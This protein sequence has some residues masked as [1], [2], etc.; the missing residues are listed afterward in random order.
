M[1]INIKVNIYAI[2]NQ[3]PAWYGEKEFSFNLKRLRAGFFKSF[4]NNFKSVM[5][6]IVHEFGHEY[7]DDHL[8]NKYYEALC[9]IG[10]KMTLLALEEPEFFN[11]KGTIL[12]R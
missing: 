2:N 4:P 7:S 3:F 10:A 5:E 6:L 9:E 1:G 11:Y 8:S 12:P